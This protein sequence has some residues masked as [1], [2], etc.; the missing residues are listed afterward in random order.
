MTLIL[1]SFAGGARAVE[2]DEKVKAPMARTGVETQD[3]GGEL[4]GEL[5]AVKGWFSDG[6]GY[7]QGA[8]S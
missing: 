3:A 5:F 4:L 6:A 1:A 2:F 8:H 7:K